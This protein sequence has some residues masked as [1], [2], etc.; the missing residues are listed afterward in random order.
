MAL[1]DVSKMQVKIESEDQWKDLIDQSEEKLLGILF[2]NIL[3]YIYHID[4]YFLNFMN[5]FA[6]CSC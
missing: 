5:S 2:T 4:N 6:S 1:R 3:L